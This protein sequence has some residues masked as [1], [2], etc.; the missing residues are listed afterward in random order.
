MAAAKYQQTARS[1]LTV[2]ERWRVALV[3][4]KVARGRRLSAGDTK[5]WS[6]VSRNLRDEVLEPDCSEGSIKEPSNRNETDGGTVR[7][8]SLAAQRR[9]HGSPLHSQQKGN[10]SP[11]QLSPREAV[12]HHVHSIT[13]RSYTVAVS[14]R[15]EGHGHGVGT[16]GITHSLEH[17]LGSVPGASLDTRNKH[18]RVAAG[19]EL[20]DSGT[21]SKGDCGDATPG[22]HSFRSRPASALSSRRS[23]SRDISPRNSLKGQFEQSGDE[24]NAEGSSSRPQSASPYNGRSMRARS[25][26]SRVP[27]QDATD[28]P[29][30]MKRKLSKQP[31]PPPTACDLA[32]KQLLATRML[33]S[34]AAAGAALR[35][36]I[37]AS[38]SNDKT[39]VFAEAA[40]AAAAAINDADEQTVDF[41]KTHHKKAP[42]P[43]SHSAHS[44][45]SAGKFATVSTHSNSSIV[46]DTFDAGLGAGTVAGAET[47]VGGVVA[48]R[49]SAGSFGGGGFLSVDVI[50]SMVRKVTFG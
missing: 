9:R 18:Y 42:T 44:A 31:A 11:R 28:A 43:R 19:V 12:A 36:S 7:L 45:A 1:A 2:R 46:E 5:I 8:H 27:S 20:D 30:A 21:H 16:D 29:P 14:P 38:F 40:A 49:P 32:N 25:P 4:G 24:G 22:M 39:R 50:R 41:R 23:S 34:L 47:N 26:I 35:S 15:H 6:V 33:K 17:S 48:A 37:R 3:Y 13:P 10:L